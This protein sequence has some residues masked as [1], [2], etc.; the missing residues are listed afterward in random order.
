MHHELTGKR[1]VHWIGIQTQIIH[2]HPW[3]QKLPEQK[4]NL[5]F[6]Y[7]SAAQSNWWISIVLWEM[8]NKT[9]FIFSLRF[10]KLQDSFISVI[11]CFTVFCRSVHV[12]IRKW[13][14]PMNP[15]KMYL[16]AASLSNKP[17]LR[18]WQFYNRTDH[19]HATTVFHVTFANGLNFIGETTDLNHPTEDRNVFLSA[20][21]LE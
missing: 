11:L 7:F 1:S 13:N 8:E 17:P 10:S 16:H 15:W 19:A 18:H 3:I 2:I 9:A 12:C 4:Q 21:F 6:I 14:E 20:G 5:E